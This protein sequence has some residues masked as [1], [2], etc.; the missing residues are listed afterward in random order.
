MGAEAADGKTTLSATD[1]R[2][3]RRRAYGRGYAV[4]MYTVALVYFG[5]AVLAG[6]FLSGSY[7]ALRWHQYGATLTDA[8]LFCALVVGALL[9]RHGKGKLWP[10][11]AALTLLLAN[12]AQNGAGAARLLSLHIPLGVAMIAGAFLVAL[13]VR[14]AGEPADT[15]T[16]A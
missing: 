10:F 12:Q 2:A 8:L 13:R 14:H 7:D 4:L 3:R 1:G 9:R 15:G 11:L 5:Q 6:Q 16:S